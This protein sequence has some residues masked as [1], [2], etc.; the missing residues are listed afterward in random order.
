MKNLKW[1]KNMH[2]RNVEAEDKKN[3]NNSLLVGTRRRGAA[4][5]I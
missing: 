2:G 5:K 4:S 1:N 3:E